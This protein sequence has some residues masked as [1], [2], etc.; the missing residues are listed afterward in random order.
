M[1]SSTAPRKLG[2]PFRIAL[3]VVT[4]IAGTI[5]TALLAFS[6]FYNIGAI[7]FEIPGNPLGAVTWDSAFKVEFSRVASALLVT[8]VSGLLVGMVAGTLAGRWILKRSA[9]GVVAVSISGLFA[10]AI[11][12]LCVDVDDSAF[13]ERSRKFRTRAMGN[14]DRDRLYKGF[15]MTPDAT[16]SE[17]GSIGKDNDPIGDDKW[18]AENADSIQRRWEECAEAREWMKYISSLQPYDSLCTD[19][20]SPII[21]FDVVR[22]VTKASVRHALLQVAEGRTEDGIGELSDVACFGQTLQ[23]GSRNLVDLMIG[24][25]IEKMAFEH[26]FNLAGSGAMAGHWAD[27]DRVLN[28]SDTRRDQAVLQAFEAD[29][30]MITDALEAADRQS[31]GIFYPAMRLVWNPGATMQRLSDAL[32][33]TANAIVYDDEPALKRLSDLT[34]HEGLPSHIAFKN[35]V[36]VLTAEYA[37]PQSSERMANSLKGLK[38]LYGRLAKLRSE[39]TSNSADAAR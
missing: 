28:W 14:I 39:A 25:V 29:A 1:T 32:T 8:A 27:L 3:G 13:L 21:D 6:L 23:G 11:L 7:K 4:G 20:G 19:V 15:R 38:Q 12:Y 18:I 33:R 31:R 2:L 5:V 26:L 22:S 34:V 17:L 24:V 10:V 35:M 16:T 9:R 36:G 30:A 37:I